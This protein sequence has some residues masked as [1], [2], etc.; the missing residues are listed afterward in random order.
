MPNH[1]AQSTT[2]ELLDTVALIKLLCENDHHVNDE[3]NKETKSITV[4]DG[5][6]IMTTKNKNIDLKHLLMQTATVQDLPNLKH[7]LIAVGKLCDAGLNITF[8]EKSA[9]IKKKWENNPLR[10]ERFEKWLM[11]DANFRCVAITQG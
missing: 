1:P 8:N 11:M 10:M 5:R 9:A 7:N 4:T 2:T 3:K 6:H